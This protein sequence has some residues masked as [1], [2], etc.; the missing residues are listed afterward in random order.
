[1][2]ERK[3]ICGVGINDA[4]YRVKEWQNLGYVAGKQKQQLIWIC[5]FYQVW[6][7]MLTRCYGSRKRLSYAECAVC[8]EWHTFSNFKAWMEMQDWKGKQ[9]DKDL[10]G[11]G[12]IYCPLS[13][14]FIPHSV[15]T[16]MTEKK[17][18]DST[19]PVGV[20]FHPDKGVRQFSAWITTGKGS[21]SF[22]GY[23]DSAE[24]ASQAYAQEKLRL[25]EKLA[26]DLPAHLAV[27][28]VKRYA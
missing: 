9:L 11:D 20:S 14:A 4:T 24:T 27:A 18:K 1:M 8:P 15:N 22:L 16:F 6:T 21:K 13:C 17:R 28:L 10:L 23:F 25:A 7:A 12:K 5:P 26:A 2:K 19:L 3:K